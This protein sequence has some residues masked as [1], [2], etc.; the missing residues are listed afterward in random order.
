MLKRFSLRQEII[1][2]V[3]IKLILL[4]FLWALCFSHPIDKTLSSADINSHL[5][6]QEHYD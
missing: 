3:L 6:S 1:L 5:L 4:Y 2:V